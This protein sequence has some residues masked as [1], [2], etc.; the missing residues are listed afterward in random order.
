MVEADC[1]FS[2]AEQ[3]EMEK[4]GNV[5]DKASSERREERNAEDSGE[6]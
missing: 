2:L 6:N 1:D 5:V 4:W 3:S